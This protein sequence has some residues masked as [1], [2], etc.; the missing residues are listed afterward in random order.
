MIL[1]LIKA[2][3]GNYTYFAVRVFNDTD[4]IIL[5]IVYLKVEIMFAVF[6]KMAT[7]FVVSIKFPRLG[8]KDNIVT[9]SYLLD[10]TEISIESAG[11][12]DSER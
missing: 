8:R 12:S 2:M 9:Y 4:F 3:S 7:F 10:F 6:V 1:Q 5:T 11:T